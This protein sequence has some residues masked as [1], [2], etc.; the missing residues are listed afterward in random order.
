MDEK[1]NEAKRNATCPITCPQASDTVAQTFYVCGTYAESYGGVTATVYVVYPNQVPR[2]KATQVVNG[3]WK[4]QFQNLPDSGGSS[5]QLGS[6]A[7]TTRGQRSAPMARSR[8]P[9]R[10]RALSIAQEN[11]RNR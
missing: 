2:S 7:P 8:S 9:F 3:G 5:V 6:V 1:A 4:V 11:A 10:A